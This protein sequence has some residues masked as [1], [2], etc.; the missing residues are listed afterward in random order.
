MR[1]S[2]MSRARGGARRD[3]A[4]GF[5]FWGTNMM[6]LYEYALYALAA[7][8]LLLILFQ[9]TAIADVIGTDLIL[10]TA[11]ADSLWSRA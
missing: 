6:H 1:I 4:T 8:L 3:L 7:C 2:E 5:V 10:V 11:Q 9:N